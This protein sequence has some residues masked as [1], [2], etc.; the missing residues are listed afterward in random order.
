MQRNIVKRLKSF[1]RSRLP[2]PVSV[3]KPAEYFR[4]ITRS[5]EGAFFRIY[6]ENKWRDMDSHS[7]PGSNLI[8]TENIRKALPLLIEELHCKSL[9]DVPCGDFFWMN[10]IQMDI[11]YIGGDIIAELIENNRRQYGSANRRFLLLNL[12]RDSLPKTD[13]ILCRDCLPHFAY[14]DIFHA[15]RNIK[16]SGS[17]YFLTT[18]YVGR[19]RNENIPSGRW[20]PINVQ[21]HP[22]DFPAPIRVIDEE[23]PEEDYRGKRL[24]LWRI[25]DLPG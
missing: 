12:I 13:L 21:L 18:T 9:L 25:S 24:G 3:W 10:M 15:V 20:R 1:V 19:E 23:C 22:F 7:G 6:R 5:P 17:T 11:E 14:S 2:F 8:H 16:A 4:M